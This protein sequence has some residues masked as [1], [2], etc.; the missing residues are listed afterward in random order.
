MS[1]TI[2]KQVMI[3][4]VV[5]GVSAPIGY[6][7]GGLHCGIRKEKL[8]LGWLIS[9]TPADAFAVYTKNLFQAAPLKVTQASLAVKQKLRGIIVNSGIANACTG[10]QGLKDAYQMRDHMAEKLATESH[11]IAVASTGII[12]EF[13][14]MDKV[15]KGIEAIKFDQQCNESFESAILTTDTREKKI[16]LQMKIDGQVV[17]IGGAAKG[18]GMINPNMATMLGF[19]TTDALI[20]P[21]A[22][23]QELKDQTNQSFNMITVDGDT[24][25]NDTVVVMANGLANNQVLN[26][27]HPEWP[28]FTE[29]LSE[30]FQF[31]AKEIARD[32][33]GATKLIEVEVEGTE[34]EADARKIAKAVISSNLVKTAIHGAD[35][36][37]GRIITAI[38]YSGVQFDVDQV[39]VKMGEKTVVEN[40]LP[41][42]YDEA[43]IK[44][45]LEQDE[46]RIFVKVGS[47][48]QTA[49]GW[50]CD[51]SYEYI[52]VNALYRT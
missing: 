9:E 11:Y 1:T 39:T 44:R 43:A 35:A 5:G 31:L 13:L 40:G 32:G 28:V 51:L 2:D 52:R 23:E 34:T 6:Q 3:K 21:I 42:R 47:S 4:K 15:T 26:Q 12:G 7:S 10:E 30:V 33:E 29:A 36:N 24:S 41:K 46:V 16:A 17:T 45:D 38:G 27:D 14:P 8:D 19:I 48:D 18:S 49:R 50:G 25:T 37:W 22:L 20:D